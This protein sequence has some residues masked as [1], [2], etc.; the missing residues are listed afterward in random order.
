MNLETHTV[1]AT[2]M[3]MP[4]IVTGR[5]AAGLVP[6]SEGSVICLMETVPLGIII[7]GKQV[8]H[9]LARLSASFW[10]TGKVISG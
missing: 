8:V 7:R 4:S 9:C 6:T 10:K 1:W 5:E 2:K 3:Y